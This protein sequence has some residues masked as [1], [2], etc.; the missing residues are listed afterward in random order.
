MRD[1]RFIL[2][3]LGFWT[4][5]FS[6]AK[7]VE[8]IQRGCQGGF[9]LLRREVTFELRRVFF[10]FP[11]PAFGL[12]FQRD[13]T[14]PEPE[15]Q[16]AIKTYRTRFF[17]RTVDTK[18]MQKK[19]NEGASDGSELFFAMKYSCRFLMIFPREAYFFI[20]RKR[21]DGKTPRCQYYIHQ[22]PYRFLTKTIEPKRYEGDLNQWCQ[23]NQL[24]ITFR[25]E[26]R[27]LGFFVQPT[28]VSI[29]ESSSVTIPG[30][31]G[32]GGDLAAQVGLGGGGG[33]FEQGGLEQG[34]M[35]P[36]LVGQETSNPYGSPQPAP[37]PG[38]AGF[39]A[40]SQQAG[41][42]PPASQTGAAGNPADQVRIQCACGKQLVGSASMRGKQ[43]RCPNCSSI[44]QF[45]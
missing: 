33:G 40:S 4:W 19:V 10:F 24:K 31:A 21:V 20:F 2:F 16:W 12:V 5:L 39:D 30:A 3:N 23:R 44:L 36:G 18:A 41:A 42:F 6:P 13:K 38:L 1:H 25:D 28:V 43:V 37:E 15:Y 14:S 27:V 45:E 17:T 26:R 9:R 11:A 32:T 7:L 35:P 29:W 8:A 34:A 22:T